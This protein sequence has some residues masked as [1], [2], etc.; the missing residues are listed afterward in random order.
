MIAIVLKPVLYFQ[1]VFR[2]FSCLLITL[3]Y[4]KYIHFDLMGQSTDHSRNIRHLSQSL[5]VC[6]CHSIEQLTGYDAAFLYTL[7]LFVFAG[8]QKTE[9]AGWEVTA[10]QNSEEVNAMTR[11]EEIKTDE[12]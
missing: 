5:Y 7:I 11:S 10:S 9:N 4:T 12:R 1:S 6:I 2:T 3:N 8:I